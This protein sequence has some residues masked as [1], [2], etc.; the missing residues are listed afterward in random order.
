MATQSPT[1]PRTAPTALAA[2]LLV[3]CL[4]ASAAEWPHWR[5]PFFNGTTD[6]TD[7]PVEWS[8]TEG[9]AWRAEL[10]GATSSER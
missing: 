7:L 1:A 8:L 5:G 2:L 3:T 9:I 4:A 10:P 6:E